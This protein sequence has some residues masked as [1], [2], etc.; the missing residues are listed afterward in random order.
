MP[1]RR[2]QA[3]PSRSQT[4][5]SMKKRFGSENVGGPGASTPS[6]RPCS[7][8]TG[9]NRAT[10]GQPL[11]GRTGPIHPTR[12]GNSC[13]PASRRAP[14]RGARAMGGCAPRERGRPARM[15]S[16]WVPLSFPAMRRPAILPVETAWARS[17]Q[18]PGSVAGRAG[19]RKWARS[20]Q[21]CAGGTPALPGRHHPMTSLHQRRS[22]GSC[23]Y[24]CFLFNN[25]RKFLPPMICLAGQGRC[26]SERYRRCR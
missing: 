15:H 2:L 10:R 14:P 9:K 5:V 22:I 7:P 1:F 24:S 11:G 4:K 17:N 23:V 6:R 13:G 21:C 16:R 20:C 12:S 8:C 25:H 18:S 19:W 3:V 26:L